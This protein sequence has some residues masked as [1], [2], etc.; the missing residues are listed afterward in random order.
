MTDADLKAMRG[1]ASKEARRER[2]RATRAKGREVEHL[3]GNIREASG[4]ASDVASHVT[5]R[6]RFAGGV[7]AREAG[8]ALS[9]FLAGLAAI[10]LIPIVASAVQKSRRRS[11]APTV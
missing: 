8:P 2:A 3:R 10:F 9:G 1:N 7:A 11:H 6:A 4:L 5:E